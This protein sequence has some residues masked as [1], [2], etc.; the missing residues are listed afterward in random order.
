MFVSPKAHLPSPGDLL[1][2][3]VVEEAVESQSHLRRR[4]ILHPDDPVKLAL[5]MVVCVCVL[6]S[7]V[8][9]PVAVGFSLTESLALLVF[10]SCTDAVFMLDM[11]RTYKT[12]DGG[13]GWV[14]PGQ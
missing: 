14:G 2:G 7:V 5:D 1:C 6:A 11:V 3:R 8:E 13:R 9:V 10:E 12:G 4:F